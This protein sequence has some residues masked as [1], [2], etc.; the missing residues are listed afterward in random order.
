MQ[1]TV[2]I[3]DRNIGAGFPC[4]IIAE[5]SGNHNMD[6]DRA[7]EIIRAAKWAG[8]DAVKLQTY[9]ADTITLD[10]RKPYFWTGSDSLWSGMTLHDLYEKAYTPWEW[11][12]KLKKLADEEGILLFSSPFDVSSV[13]FLEQ[14]DVPAYKIASYEINDIP[15]LKKAAGTGKPILLS[16]GIADMADIELALKTCQEEGND[17]VILLKCTSE[18]PASY[19]QMNLKMIPHMRETFQCITGLSDHSLGDEIALAAVALGAN[20]VE[21]HFTLDPN[22]GG[23]DAA[24][25]MGKQEWKAMVE[26]IRHIEQAFGRVSY[27]LTRRQQEEKQRSR[28]LFSCADIKAGDRFTKDNIRSVRPGMGL[29][30]KYF[31]VILGKRARRDIAYGEPL[32]MGDIEWP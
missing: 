17:Q 29:H 16:T 19:G 9:T 18:Y 27:A 6:Y 23:V 12:P 2:K 1:K 5:M 25:S 32:Q 7:R 30:T 3:A 26:R 15:L 31:D 20:V 10:S 8:A 28:S 13:D 24:F 21:K 11:Q 22:D 4:F 14:M